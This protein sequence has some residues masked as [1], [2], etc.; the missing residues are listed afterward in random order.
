MIDVVLMMIMMI[1]VVYHGL[2]VPAMNLTSESSILEVLDE[3]YH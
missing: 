2:V 3:V 1:I